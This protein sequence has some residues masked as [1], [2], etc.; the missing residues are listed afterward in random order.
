M[1]LARKY[2]VEMPIAAAVNAVLFERLDPLEAITRLM[3]CK[4]KGERV[5]QVVLR[6]KCRVEMCA[7]RVRGNRSR[8]PF[9]G[10]F[11]AARADMAGEMRITLV[12]PRG[13]P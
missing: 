12:M 11:R 7:G 1:D 9:E 6:I 13:F 4:L 3:S 2:G 5:E 10:P 8:G